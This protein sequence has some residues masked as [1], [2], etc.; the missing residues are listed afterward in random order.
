MGKGNTLNSPKFQDKRGK[1][2]RYRFGPIKF[3]VLQTNKGWLRG[4]DYHP[5]RQYIFLIKGNFQITLIK[6]KKEVK[7]IK[8]APCFFFIE[9]NI[10]HLFNSLNDTIMV[11]F[12]ESIL[13]VK[14]Y[15]PFRK[16]IRKQLN[17]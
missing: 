11:E 9:K 15:E 6:D 12:G 14:Y 8:K 4:G 13:N 1:I 2:R 16:I 7:I 5:N 10:P 3:N 17:D